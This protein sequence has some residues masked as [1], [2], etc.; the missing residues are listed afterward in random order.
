MKYREMQN[1][2]RTGLL[3][4]ILAIISART[5]QA[6]A[7]VSAPVEMINGKAYYV[8]LVQKGETA[9]AIS[10]MYECPVNDILSANPGIDQGLK[11]GQKVNVPVDKSKVKPKTESP[12]RG[13]TEHEV[14]KKETLYSIA[15]RYNVDINELA[16]ANPGSDKGISKGQIL[17]IPV[18]ASPAEIKSVPV[19]EAA[20]N[21]KHI[22]QQ[23]ETLYGIARQYQIPVDVLISANPGLSESLKLGQEISIPARGDGSQP[24]LPVHVPLGNNGNFR[25]V[26]VDGAVVESSY[27][28]ALML[29]FMTNAVDTIGLTPKEKRLQDVAFQFFRGASMGLDSAQHYGLSADVYSFDI[30]DNRNAAREILA[31]KEL[32]GTDLIIGPAFRDPL[33]EVAMWG[34]K[35]GAHV[36]CPVPQANKVLLTSPNMSKAYPS[37]VTQWETLGTYIGTKHRNDNVVLVNSR[38]V[39]D[40]KLI[41]VFCSAYFR[42]AGDS[43]KQFQVKGRSAS[44]VSKLLKPSG[45]NIVIAPS[46][47]K[48]L[49]T[50]LFGDLNGDNITVFGKEDWEDSPVIEPQKRNELHVSYPKAIF[51][52]YSDE[53]VQIWVEAYRKRFHTEP[54]EYSFL[55]Y[56]VMR[57]YG[58]GLVLF[59]KDFPNHFGEWNCTG[60]VSTSFKFVRTGDESGFE[61]HHAFVISTE[62]F[63]LKRK[64]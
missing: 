62:E 29:P 33:Q 9:Y 18:R 22:V 61:N 35:N 14:K 59:G 48:L 28:I 34:G 38:D 45:R 3:V 49:I 43:V 25:P 40:L 12:A 7:Q 23:G 15:K 31:R 10:R 47:D 17:K 57:Y 30:A 64:N 5:N 16:A 13:F 60:C 63:E 27:R 32:A 24:G 50:T 41:Q 58:E 55:G 39:D 2:I 54:T 44:G 56:D 19:I 51:P 11:E 53:K 52:D 37:E 6:M 46:S 21:G 8:H 26:P 36:V 1:L 20:P 4:L 42:A